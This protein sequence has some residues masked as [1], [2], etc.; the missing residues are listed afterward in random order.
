MVWKNWG[1]PL[2]RASGTKGIQSWHTDNQ[3]LRA[4]KEK[5][6]KD[7]HWKPSKAF[8]EGRQGQSPTCLKAKVLV[9]QSCPTLCDPIDCDPLGSSVHG[10]LQA[11][12][13]EWVAI[14]FSRGSPQPRNQIRVSCIAGRFFTV[15][16]TREAPIE[17]KCIINIMRLNCPQTILLPSPRKNC[18]LWNWFLVPKRLGTTGL[19]DLSPLTRDWTRAMALKAQNLNH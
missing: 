9:A 13:L 10:I 5:T 17:I 7:E 4:K 11:R 14:P 2:S 18:L 3:L 19:E 8:D 12:I 16:A 1:L 15:W 6:L